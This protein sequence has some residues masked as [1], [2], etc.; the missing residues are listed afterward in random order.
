MRQY[1]GV[2]VLGR[3]MED[4]A[5]FVDK[6]KRFMGK[7]QKE[8][9]R[10]SVPKRFFLKGEL[11]CKTVKNE[12]EYETN[13]NLSNMVE[14]LAEEVLYK[15]E[16]SPNPNTLFRS[17]AKISSLPIVQLSY[18]EHQGKLHT[19]TVRLDTDMV[20]ELEMMLADMDEIKQ[21]DYTVEKVL[22]LWYTNFINDVVTGCN[23]TVINKI[24]KLS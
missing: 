14:M 19:F 4:P 24:L 9:L 3:A 22:E 7:F 12:S 5:G 21:H 16:V 20:F 11:I 17:L 2:N 23:E 1:S 10:I 13:F 15:Y 18:G 6:V 8:K